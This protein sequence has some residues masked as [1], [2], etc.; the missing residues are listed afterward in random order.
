MGSKNYVIE[1]WKI[2]NPWYPVAMHFVKL[3]P[4]VTG[5]LGTELELVFLGKEVMKQYVAQVPYVVWSVH[6]EV[7]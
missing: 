2:G 1:R 5:E 6:S 3:L 4:M 7:L